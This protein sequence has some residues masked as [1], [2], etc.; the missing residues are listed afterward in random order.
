MK[1]LIFLILCLI[2]QAQSFSQSFNNLEFRFPD[3]YESTIFPYG[4]SYV[5]GNGSDKLHLFADFNDCD[6]SS[7]MHH[8]INFKGGILEIFSDNGSIKVFGGLKLKYDRTKKK[9]IIISSEGVENIR[10][11]KWVPVAG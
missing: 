4:Y 1:K 5:E 3:D 10:F 9:M 11:K 8:N 6:W 2:L 7:Y